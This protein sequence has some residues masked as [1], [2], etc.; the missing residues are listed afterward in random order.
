MFFIA[1]SLMNETSTIASKETEKNGHKRATLFQ[2]ISLGLFC[3]LHKHTPTTATLTPQNLTS[4][5]IF[6][7]DLCPHLCFSLH[8]T[9]LFFS[10]ASYL[11]SSSLSLHIAPNKPVPSESLSLSTP[12]SI[13]V[14]FYGRKKSSLLL[15]PH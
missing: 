4:L 3:V 9:P 5:S 2:F 13:L 15:A 11:F 8:L 14:L 1:C 12:S 6:Y 10:K 7:L